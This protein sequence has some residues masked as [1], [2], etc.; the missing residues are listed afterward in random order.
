MSLHDRRTF[1]MASA[2]ALAAASVGAAADPAADSYWV[3]FGTNTGG[4]STSKGIYRS[5]VD[6]KAGTLTAPELA[7]EVTN[8]TFL[9]VHPTNKFLYSVGEVDSTGGKR[10]GGVHAPTLTGRLPMACRDR[11]RPD[12]RPGRPTLPARTP[13]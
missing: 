4:K 12:L 8:P 10:A 11:I 5:R 6:P 3:F 2:A 7:A 13:T 1:L 9:A